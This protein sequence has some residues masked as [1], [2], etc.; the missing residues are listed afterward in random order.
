M[1]LILEDGIGRADA[2]SYADLAFADG[3]H[4]PRGRAGWAAAAAEEREAALIKATDYLDAVYD[5]RGDR[6]RSE[7]ALAWPRFCAE[8][9][10]GRRMA[11]VPDAVRR[12]CAELALRA[13]T[14]DLLP[15]EARG[16]RVTSETLGPISTTYDA[17]APAGT[18]RRLVDG[19]LRGVV[20]G[21]RD[22]VRA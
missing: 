18:L 8:D 4:A 3:Y 14:E 21:G 22:V 11:G 10:A 19:L 2:N 16:G 1:S 20:R 7:Q 9:D 6:E 15:D 17:D 12:A 5:F 13:L